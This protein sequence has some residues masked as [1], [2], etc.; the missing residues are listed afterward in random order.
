MKLLWREPTTVR[1]TIV[2]A[3]AL[4]VSVIAGYATPS[5]VTV[6]IRGD[7]D[8][9]MADAGGLEA[10]KKLFE[11]VIHDQRQI[12]A[13]HL[14]PDVTKVPQLWALF[15]EVQQYYDAGL[16][17][18]D[19]VTLLFAGDN[20]GDL[21]RLPT[22]EER[23]RSGGAASPISAF[24]EFAT[25]AHARNIRIYGAT[26]TPF[27]GS[28]YYSAEHEAIRQEVNAWIRT[29]SVF[30]GLIDFDAAVRDPAGGT[31]FKA[32]YHPG[33]NG[34]DWLHLNPAGYRALAEAIDLD[35]FNGR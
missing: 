13:E 4:M 20:V 14:N 3:I 34:N 24:N 11:K 5:L 27:G 18:P 33:L 1:R 22:P 10:S 7:G 29:N 21:R 32:E 12:L 8:V 17:L 30:D 28:G 23:K 2:S 25:K 31:K 16:K 19:D 26:V 35:L 9:A 6:G 15:T